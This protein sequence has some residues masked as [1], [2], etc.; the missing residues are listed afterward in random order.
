MEPDLVPG[1]D[2]LPLGDDAGGAVDIAADQVSR[3]S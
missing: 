1:L 3:K 2:V